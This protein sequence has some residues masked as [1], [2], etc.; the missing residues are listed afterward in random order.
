M[1]Y[2]KF[3]DLTPEQQKEAVDNELNDLLKEITSGAIRFNDEMNGDDLQARIDKAGEDANK[4][5]VTWFWHEFIMETCRE[6]L[7]SIARGTAQT[8]VFAEDGEL[9]TYEHRC[10]EELHAESR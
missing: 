6:D 4:Q 8:G 10:P 1:N 7:E 2:K 5:Q 9:V 3:D